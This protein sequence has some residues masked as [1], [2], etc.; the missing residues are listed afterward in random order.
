MPIIV[1]ATKK[2]DLLDIAFSKKR[3]AMKQEGKRFDEEACEEY[4][5]EQ[6][7]ERIETIRSEMQSVP[8]GRLDACVAT[9][10]GKQNPP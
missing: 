2:D 4:A 10:V 6:L 5:E 3:K 1:V 8:G 9:A 7:R